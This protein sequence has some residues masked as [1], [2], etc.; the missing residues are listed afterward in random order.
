MSLGAYNQQGVMK[1]TS[2]DR[3]NVRANIDGK[4]TK[5][6]DISLGIAL[7]QEG[8]EEP[9]VNMKG[10]M[11]SAML[12][13]PY[14]PAETYTGIPVAGVNLSGNQSSNPLAYRDLNGAKN[15]VERRLESNISL[16]Y[17]VFGLKGLF[18][19]F[20]ASYDYQQKMTKSSLL[21]LN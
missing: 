15:S 17:N 3:Y 1:G 21:P 2:Y 19:K 7:R 20:T 13:H 8:T 16:K 11:Q 9:S 18:A 4:V 12:A 6:F 14:L 5:H 10:I